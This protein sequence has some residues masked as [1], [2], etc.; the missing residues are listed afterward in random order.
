MRIGGA[1]GFADG[2]GGTNG[3]NGISLTSPQGQLG[4]SLAAG[5]EAGLLTGNANPLTLHNSGI[6]TA[7]MNADKGSGSD[8]GLRLMSLAFWNFT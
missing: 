3:K 5:I 8:S 7:Y 2:N 1:W 4:T 6:S